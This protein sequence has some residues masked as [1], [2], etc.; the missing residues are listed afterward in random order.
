MQFKGHTTIQALLDSG[1]EVNAITLAY[2]AVVG[3]GI[4]SIDVGAQKIDRLILLTHGMVLAIFELE[5]KH[6]K[7]QF[8][9][10][11]FLVTD[12]AMEVV[13]GIPFLS[14]NKIEINFA[15]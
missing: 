1:S 13:L 3:L 11:T 7:T 4:R 8:F 15:E 6:G 10:E 9:Q 12:T 14:L 5:D 2:V